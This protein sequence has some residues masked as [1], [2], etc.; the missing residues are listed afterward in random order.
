[1]KQISD[2][3]RD[4]LIEPTTRAIATELSKVGDHW[5]PFMELNPKANLFTLYEAGY[6]NES[7]RDCVDSMER[8]LSELN[9]R[10][11]P[12]ILYT[13]ETYEIQYPHKIRIEGVGFPK[14]IELAYT[15]SAVGASAW[16]YIDGRNNGGY[17]EGL[18]IIYNYRGLIHSKLAIYVEEHGGF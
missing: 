13:M 11:D 14:L 7:L 17:L 3:K 18:A 9:T 1:M 5:Y 15:L 16:E 4:P 10:F 2:L 6:A 12:E 8:Q